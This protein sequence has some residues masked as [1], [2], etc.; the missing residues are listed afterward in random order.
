MSLLS[1]LFGRKKGN[2]TSVKEHPSEKPRT[3]THEE[4]YD[5]ALQSIK[6]QY[7]SRY[8]HVTI[9]SPGEFEDEHYTYYLAKTLYATQEGHILQF[10]YVSRVSSIYERVMNASGKRL[11]IGEVQDQLK[12]E[13]VKV[14]KTECGFSKIDL[15]VDNDDISSLQDDYIIPEST[16]ILRCDDCRGSGYQNC[17]DEEC[18]GRHEYKCPRCNGRG[19]TTCKTCKGD[20]KLTCP[21]CRGKGE[22]ACSSCNGEGISVCKECKGRGDIKC[23]K[24]SGQGKIRCSSCLGT[25]RNNNGG[26]CTRCFGSGYLTCENCSGR[27]TYICPTCRGKRSI[28]CN[29]CG[30]NGKIVC[31][32]CDGKAV[33]TCSDCR[34]EGVITCKYCR[35][36][37]IIICQ[38]C[39]GDKEHYGM[40]ECPECRTSGRIAQ[41]GYI[42]TKIERHKNKKS[43]EVRNKREHVSI[44]ELLPENKD[45]QVIYKNINGKIYKTKDARALEIA[46]RID[47][48]NNLSKMLNNPQIIEQQ[49][50]YRDIYCISI[51][52][53]HIMTKEKFS[54]TVAD[55][56]GNPIVLFPDYD[57]KQKL[58]TGLFEGLGY[59]LGSLF[60]TKKHLHRMDCFCLYK[61]YLGL[62]QV[63]DVMD[64]NEKRLILDKLSDFDLLT[65]KQKNA[66]REML[67]SS[68]HYEPTIEDVRFSSEEKAEEALA[69]L[70]KLS[71][72]DGNASAT[73]IEY[74]AIVDE[75]IRQTK[76]KPAKQSK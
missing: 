70:K 32:R 73:E 62:A 35:G 39:L 25:G 67:N 53:Q 64:D 63:D 47:E 8:D 21:E 44:E 23:R 61:L 24:C 68:S 6:T 58:N 9:L 41:I 20:K 42:E 11:A 2:T 7:P 52:C 65:P 14:Q 28:T 60:K 22:M 71:E 4:I 29:R 57:K 18:G 26:R 17:P 5:I 16:K 54:I 19:E 31:R 38:T 56:L 55:V 76:Y 46:L 45:L 50:F 1:N 13:N 30:G 10:P 27:G 40:I 72:V 74:I 33:L 48:E 49:L 34:G 59:A 69:A 66:L 3:Y 51:K 36:D 12:S 43:P 15:E 37:G 75:L